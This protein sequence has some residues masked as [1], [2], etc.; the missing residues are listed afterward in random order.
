LSAGSITTPGSLSVAGS[1]S[2][3]N[4]TLERQITLG[5]SGG[6]FYGNATRAGWFKTGGG[7]FYIEANT[8]NFVAS[9]NVTAY[10]DINLKTDLE[11][12]PNAL[13]KILQLTGYTYTR[14]DTNERQTGL[15]A[16]DVEK[17]LPEA[18][19]Q[20]DHLSLAYGNLAGLLVEAIK[21]LTDKVSVLDTE[22]KE[23]KNR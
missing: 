13:S 15:I 2:I 8:G 14:T 23:L 21:E 3:I 4:E 22:I 5:S 7:S 17:V 10:S 1:V 19:I 20:G 18:V 9:G 11:V 16:Q 6:Y 12:I